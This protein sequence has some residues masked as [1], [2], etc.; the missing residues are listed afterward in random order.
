MSGPRKA[1]KNCKADV[2][3]FE[4]ALQGSA[5]PWENIA[6]SKTGQNLP[7]TCLCNIQCV[8]R[9]VNQNLLLFREK[10]LHR[11]SIMWTG[12]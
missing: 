10:W 12:C 6:E 8:A 4:F 2:S 11:D 9:S 1:I 7:T 3:Q 5:L